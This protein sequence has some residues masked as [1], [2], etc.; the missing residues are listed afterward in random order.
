MRADQIGTILV[1]SNLRP[2]AVSSQ[3]R[4]LRRISQ[5]ID[6]EN[7]ENLDINSH[8]ALVLYQGIKN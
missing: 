3:G 2:V 1:V 4:C 7:E 6:R 5:L 8:I